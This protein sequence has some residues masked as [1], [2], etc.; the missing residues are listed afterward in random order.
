MLDKLKAMFSAPAGGASGYASPSVE[1]AAAA[2]MVEIAHA[3]HEDDPRE[4]NAIVEIARQTLALEESEA[5][6]LLDD[7]KAHKDSA[8]SLYEFTD[9]LNRNFDKAQKIRLVEDCWKVAFADGDIDRYE[10]HMIRRIA[11]LLYVSHSDF[12]RAKLRV[13]GSE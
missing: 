4:A 11:E 10:D 7:A 6:Q 5:R 2:L 1:L 12:I 9:L 13:S 8:T 3:D